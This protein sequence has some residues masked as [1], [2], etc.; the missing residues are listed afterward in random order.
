MTF[1]ASQPSTSSCPLANCD[2]RN[3]GGGGWICC[4][5]GGAN[6]SGWCN[7]MSPNPRWE[8]NA[9]TDEWEWIERCDHGCCRNCTK[10][11]KCRCLA[12]QYHLAHPNG[13]SKPAT[14]LTRFKL[15]VVSATRAGR[16]AE[17]ESDTAHARGI[18]PGSIQWRRTISRWT[19][20]GRTGKA[21]HER[22]SVALIG[23]RI[24]KSA[25]PESGGKRCR[26]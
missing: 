18:R 26:G 16:K 14:S 22:S 12:S 3:A 15:R 21:R 19:T 7:N 1:A 11:C 17:R 25:N 2:F 13:L 6:T 24:R 9:V 5:C 20:A 23:R 4:N 10:D 8:K